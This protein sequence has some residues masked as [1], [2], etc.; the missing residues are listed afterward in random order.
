MSKITARTL[1]F[2]DRTADVLFCAE[3]T[4]FLDATSGGLLLIAAFFCADLMRFIALNAIWPRFL[5]AKLSFHPIL[6][7]LI[8]EQD[9]IDAKWL[10]KS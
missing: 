8:A 5:G 6:Y 2:G 9:Q 7:R 10:E 4:L 3:A 1:T